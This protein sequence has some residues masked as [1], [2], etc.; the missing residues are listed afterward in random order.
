MVSSLKSGTLD[1]LL[2]HGGS[3]RHDGGLRV[4]LGT[5]SARQDRDGR[6]WLNLQEGNRKRDHVHD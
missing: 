4:R 5:L 2:N 6:L 3:D 1:Q